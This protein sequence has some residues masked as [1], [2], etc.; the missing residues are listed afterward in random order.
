MAAILVVDDDKSIRDLVS[1][2]LESEGNRVLSAANGAEAVAVY[3]S[4]EGQIDLV[5]TD[6]DMPV[7][8][9]VE[10]ILHIRMTNP[11]AKVICMTGAS[12]QRCPAG[13]MLLSKPFSAEKLFQAVDGA[14]SA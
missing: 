4:H 2:M 8:D 11:A 3:R 5:L 13:V 6:M 14:T 7:M 9:G 12:E 10:E 1:T